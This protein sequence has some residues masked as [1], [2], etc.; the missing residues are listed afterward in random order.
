MFSGRSLI[1]LHFSSWFVFADALPGRLGQKR[2]WVRCACGFERIHLNIALTKGETTRCRA[3]ANRIRFVTHDASHSRLY[4][5]WKNIR[6][7]CHDP[8]NHAFKR[9]GGRGIRVCGRWRNSFANFLAD[10]GPG[11][12]GWTVE[13]VDN[14]A[15]YSVRNCVWATMTRQQRNKRTNLT[16]TIAGVTKCLMDWC[17]HYDVPWYLARNRLKAGWPLDRL[18]IL[19][20]FRCRNPRDITKGFVFLGAHPS[21]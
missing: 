2:S 7:R 6:S 20:D 12:T 8:L 13:R 1:G 19:K 14:F 11:K 21:D 17:E 3:C 9:Y 5:V 10:M 4:S 16:V 15:G 18:F